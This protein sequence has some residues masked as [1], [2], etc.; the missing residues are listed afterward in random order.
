M[1]FCSDMIKFES[2]LR[3]KHYTSSIRPLIANGSSPEKLNNQL[4]GS[5][6]FNRLAKRKAVQVFALS[7]KEINKGLDA[8][9]TKEQLQ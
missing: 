9:T 5:T 1:K 3:T 8:K 4:V 2:P 6:T 7:L